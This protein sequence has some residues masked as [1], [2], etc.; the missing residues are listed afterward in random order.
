[1]DKLTQTI[2]KGIFMIGLTI[3]LLAVIKSLNSKE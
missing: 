1:M 3:V 2:E